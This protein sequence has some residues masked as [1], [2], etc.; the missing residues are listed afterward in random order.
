M[1]IVVFIDL[2][3]YNIDGTFARSTGFNLNNYNKLKAERKS[4]F[5]V[6]GSRFTRRLCGGVK[7][8]G[9]GDRAQ[10]SWVRD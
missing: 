6:L 3:P 2:L 7:V 5:T 8:Q 4:R 10:G 1:D 9:I